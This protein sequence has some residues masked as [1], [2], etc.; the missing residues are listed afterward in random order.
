[1]SIKNYQPRHRSGASGRAFNGK[2]QMDGLY[3]GN[4][5]WRKYR[6]RFLEANSRCYSCGT[7]ST[8]VDHVT[9]HLGDV[10][11]FERLDNHIPLC[12]RC[13]NTVTAKFDRRYVRGE[14]VAKKLKWLSDNRL[15]KSLTFRVK[16]LPSYRTR[17]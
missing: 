16:V 3:R 8:V 11:L 5:D 9:P 14:P 6:D 4:E 10:A 15:A 1:M 2:K 7:A 13:H 12:E 17:E